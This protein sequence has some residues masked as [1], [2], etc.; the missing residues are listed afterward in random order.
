MQY[1]LVLLF[2]VNSPGP[3]PAGVTYDEVLRSSVSVTPGDHALSGYGEFTS[4]AKEGVA[5]RKNPTASAYTIR[6]VAS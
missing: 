5:I 2:T 3:F 1:V 6:T 4:H